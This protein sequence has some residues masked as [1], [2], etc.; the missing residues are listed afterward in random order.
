MRDLSVKLL[1][2]VLGGRLPRLE[3]VP[4]LVFTR[5]VFEEALRREPF[6]PRGRTIRIH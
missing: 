1:H 4:R 3:D 2:E 6:L 5:A